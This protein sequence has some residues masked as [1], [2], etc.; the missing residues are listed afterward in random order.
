MATAASASSAVPNVV[1]ARNAEVRCSRPHGSDRYPECPATP[2]IASGCSDCSSSARIPPT[3]I[4]ASSC[5]RQIGSVSLNHREP[6]ASQIARA[7]SSAPSP[8]TLSRN[9]FANQRRVEGMLTP[10]PHPGT[11]APPGGA[12]CVRAAH[13]TQR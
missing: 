7:L 8:T 9:E 1:R 13:E 6:S 11:A 4:D 5:T 2:A 10:H 3:N 12:V